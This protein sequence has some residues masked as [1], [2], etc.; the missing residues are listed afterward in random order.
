M[1]S[2]SFFHLILDLGEILSSIRR[3]GS[4]PGLL[5]LRIPDAERLALMVM[6]MVVAMGGSVCGNR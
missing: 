4:E 5:F 6:T 3:P 2:S 1:D